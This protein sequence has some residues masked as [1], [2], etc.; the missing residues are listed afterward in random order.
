MTKFIGM[1][2]TLFS[3]TAQSEAI[4]W[5][6]NTEGGKIVLTDE[7]CAKSGSVAYVLSNTSETTMGCWTSDSVAVHVLWSGKYLRS[8]DY[9]GWI[10]VKKDSEPTM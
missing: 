10:V 4:M 2:L 9:N 8:Y 7:R 6:M 5:C 1:A 3:L